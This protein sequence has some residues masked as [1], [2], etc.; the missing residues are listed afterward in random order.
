MQNEYVFSCLSTKQIAGKS[1][2][3]WMGPVARVNIMEPELI[4][5]ILMNNKDFKKPTP[6]PLAKFLVSGLSGYEDEKWSKHR[7]IINPAFFVDKL[8]AR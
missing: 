2:F 4:K 5:E 3:T 8:K 7:K 1:S 6:N